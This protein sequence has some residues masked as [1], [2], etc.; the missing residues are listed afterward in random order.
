[1]TESVK[2]TTGSPISGKNIFYFIQSIHDKVGSPALMPA[3]R[4][5]GETTFG[6]D[7][8]D[9]QTQQGRVL[10]KGTDEHEIE[11]TQYC[12]AGDESLKVI[13]DAQ[14]TGDSVKVW[15]V[16][17]D[18]D[19]AKKGTEEGTKLYPAKFG[20]AKVSECSESSGVEDL[21]EIN[22]TLSIIDS[23]K[24]GEFP[25]TDQ[26]IGMLESVYTYQNPGEST[27]DY[28]NIQRG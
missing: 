3:Y 17:V 23:L 24:D 28:N 8:I 19:A 26:A 7:F 22:Y 11:L 10:K 5:D 12:V 2:V 15:R 25:L 16:I 6:G 27:G 21:V 1:M 13:Q 18:K 4:T 9:E 20:Y 14:R